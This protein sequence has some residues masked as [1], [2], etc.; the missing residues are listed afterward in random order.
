MNYKLLGKYFSQFRSVIHMN[1]LKLSDLAT[2][3]PEKLTDQQ[4]LEMNEPCPIKFETE[5][6]RFWRLK[7]LL[8]FFED[9]KH[10]R[11]SLAQ[12][13]W[14][15]FLVELRKLGLSTNEMQVAHDHFIRRAYDDRLGYNSLFELER[16]L[17]LTHGL[18]EQEQYALATVQE[19]IKDN[20]LMQSLNRDIN[21][22]NMGITE[23]VVYGANV[24]FA[25]YIDRIQGSKAGDIVEKPVFRIIKNGEIEQI[26]AE[27]MVVEKDF[28]YT[29][30]SCV[31]VPAS[32]IVKETF[33]DCNISQKAFNIQ[34]MEKS[35]RDLFRLIKE[36][37][38]Q[39]IILNPLPEN[40][41]EIER[42][43]MLD[44]NDEL[45][46]ENIKK[47]KLILG[48]K[49]YQEGQA[50]LVDKNSFRFNSDPIDELN[51]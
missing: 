15:K 50:V 51:L 3:T 43:A 16:Q 35:E 5:T 7:G 29:K 46:I 27:G 20:L 45:N 32:Q 28:D 39:E 44:E 2:R 31:I 25:Y 47:V 18:T 40:T 19:I 23:H 34:I 1:Q 42:Y 48:T 14:L 6:I 8:P 49:Q 11:I 10:A 22:F 41:F 30:H 12:F 9:K 37:R 17:K 4:V 33:Y 26:G 13:M 24:V 36:K 21:Y 38:A